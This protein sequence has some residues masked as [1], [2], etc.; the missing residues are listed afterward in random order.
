[1]IVRQLP[2]PTAEAGLPPPAV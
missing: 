1:L 2:P